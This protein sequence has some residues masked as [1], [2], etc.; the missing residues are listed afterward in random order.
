MTDQPLAL[1]MADIP[2]APNYFVINEDDEPF[3]DFK[4]EPKKK[5]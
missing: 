1:N 5:K 4:Y 2:K 3:I